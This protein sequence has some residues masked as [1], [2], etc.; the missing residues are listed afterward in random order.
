M[1]TQHRWQKNEDTWWWMWVVDWQTNCYAVCNGGNGSSWGHQLG[2]FLRSLE[3]KSQWKHGG[4]YCITFHNFCYTVT[5]GILLVGKYSLEE[6]KWKVG[7]LRLKEKDKFYWTPFLGPANN[8]PSVRILGW[9]KH[10]ILRMTYADCIWGIINLR[11]KSM[12]I[13]FC[14]FKSR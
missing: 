2:A 14:F 4:L 6:K 12:Q 11:T 7:K 8:Y 1:R 13:I 5:G 9:I 3:I 10:E